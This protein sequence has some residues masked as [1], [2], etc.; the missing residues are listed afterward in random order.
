MS[1]IL[2]AYQ[3]H[4]QAIRRVIAKYRANA[5]DIDELA[6]DVFLTGFSLE[7]REEIREPSHLLLRIA[8]NLAIN[9]ANRLI[10]KT[11]LPLEDS[12]DLS[13]YKDEKQ[14]SPEENLEGKRK[15]VIFSEALANLSPELRRT[16]IMRRVNGLKI[17]QIA[18]RLNVSKS[19][20]EKRVASA[21]AQCEAYIVAKGFDP[22][23]FGAKTKRMTKVNKELSARPHKK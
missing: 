5:A 8:K 9:D 15:L 21:M 14:F 3:Q 6:Q 16:F 13:V 4:K 19:L 22:K 17:D 10:N 20:V 18:R 11:S 2:Q 23:E 12:V 1:R 7:M